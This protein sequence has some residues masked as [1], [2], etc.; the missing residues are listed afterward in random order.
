MKD[1]EEIY[2]T[3]MEKVYGKEYLNL[4]CIVK[5]IQKIRESYI[6]TGNDDKDFF[7]HLKTTNDCLFLRFRNAILE[8][9]QKT[10]QQDDSEELGLIE[11]LLGFK[12]PDLLACC[13]IPSSYARLPSGETLQPTIEFP[14]L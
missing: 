8:I 14:A 1:S 11:K 12:I 10:P 9:Q 3:G 6:K 2:D 5:E 4:F 7:K 13:S